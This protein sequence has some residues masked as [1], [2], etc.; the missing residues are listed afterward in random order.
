MQEKYVLPHS[1]Q[2]EVGLINLCEVKSDWISTH[3]EDGERKPFNS[4]NIT[5]PTIEVIKPMWDAADTIFEK[6]KQIKKSSDE[7]FQKD[8]NNLN[9]ITDKVAEL[10]WIVS[11]TWPYERGSAGIAD[12]ITKV[13]FDWLK[14]HTPVWKDTANPNIIALLNPLGEFKKKYTSL[15]QKQLNWE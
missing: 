2:T 10:Y 4:I 14:I 5:S 8:E 12:L 7:K 3:D 6:I 11:Q 9:I 13:I 1:Y 15:Y